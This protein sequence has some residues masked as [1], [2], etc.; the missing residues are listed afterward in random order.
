MNIQLFM[1]LIDR[2]LISN[3]CLHQVGREEL[4]MNSLS[5]PFRALFRLDFSRPWRCQ[6]IELSCPFRAWG[7][8]AGW[9]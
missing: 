4:L 9:T 1:L 5:C 6:W 3:E 8:I 2:Y 7:K